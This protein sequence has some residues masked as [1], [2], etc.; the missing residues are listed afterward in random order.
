[1][2][3]TLNKIE[4]VVINP[5]EYVKKNMYDDTEITTYVVINF[6]NNNTLT[7]HPEGGIF[8]LSYDDIY[9]N[10]KLKC[11][12]YMVKSAKYFFSR[13]QYDVIE[14]ESA[15]LISN[16]GVASLNLDIKY[17]IDGEISNITFLNNI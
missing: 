17:K 10:E 14:F 4:T 15:N 13:N 8:N 1:M 16:C 11:K 9:E 5:F 3:T 12:F 6:P 2:N 7:I